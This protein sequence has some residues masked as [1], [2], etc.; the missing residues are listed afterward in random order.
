MHLIPDAESVKTVEPSFC[1][2]E[3]TF[4]VSVTGFPPEV[5]NES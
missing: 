5:V 1:Q 4:S 2:D 3:G